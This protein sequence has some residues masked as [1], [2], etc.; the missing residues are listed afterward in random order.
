MKIEIGKIFG[1]LVVVQPSKHKYMYLCRCECGVTKDI[2][3]YPL[4]RGQV[5]SCGCLRRQK[6]RR[7]RVNVHQLSYSRTYRIWNGMRD[8]CTNPRNRSWS[9]Y[10][11]RGITICDHW[12]QPMNFIKDMG[13]APP[14]MSI[15]RIDDDLGYE[16]MNCRWETAREQGANK[17]NNRVIE[18]AGRRKHLAEWARVFGIHR[19]TLSSRLEVHPLNVVFERLLFYSPDVVV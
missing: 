18:F 5:V 13:M 7:S 4:L 11:G 19:D 9:D 1:R 8:R 3:K 15:G 6:A 17:R 16:K 10:G 12:V 2:S 14:G